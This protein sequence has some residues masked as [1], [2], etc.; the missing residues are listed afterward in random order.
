MDPITHGVIGLAISSFSGEPVSLMNPVSIGCALGAMSPDIDAVVRVFYNDYVYLKHHRGATHSIP[1]IA[2]IA[3][4]ITLGLSFFFPEM[5]FL[6]VLFW[7]FLG[8][9]SHT[10]FDILNSY[11]AQLFVKKRKASILTL[12]D[13]VITV[14][15]LVLIFDQD[16]SP[17]WYGL[18]VLKFGLYLLFR[19]YMKEKATQRIVEEYGSGYNVLKVDVL[20]SLTAFWKW[21]FIITAK[22]HHIVGKYN[23]VNKEFKIIKKFKKRNPEIVAHFNK[24]KVGQYFNDFSPNLHIQHHEEEDRIVLFAIDMRYYMRKQFMH[25]AT[26]VFDKDYN[27]IESHFH[28]YSVNTWIPVYEAA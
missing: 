3:T 17:L 5:A 12:Y 28:P 25:H 4:A 23:Q 1:A 15:A 26:V 8:G 13:P 27:V 24:T 22:S 19:V 18:I 10:V 14:L 7:T 11:G 21:D 6:K 9:L 20:P 16:L 2:V